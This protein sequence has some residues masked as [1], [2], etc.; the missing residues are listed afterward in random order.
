MIEKNSPSLRLEKLKMMIKIQFY[1]F[2]PLV[3]LSIKLPQ[4]DFDAKN[5]FLSKDELN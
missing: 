2:F 3:K 1:L 5:E 4:Y